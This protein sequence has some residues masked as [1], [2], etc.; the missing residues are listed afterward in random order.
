MFYDIVCLFIFT[1]LQFDEITFPFQR[2]IYSVNEDDDKE[3]HKQCKS[4]ENNRAKLK[5]IYL[6]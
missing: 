4:L 1:N 2:A 6:R 5:W 3:G